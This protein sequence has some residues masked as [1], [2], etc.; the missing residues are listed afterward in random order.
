MQ[1]I[2][3][4]VQ[5]HRFR[6]F[7]DVDIAAEQ[8][9]VFSG[10]NNSG[11]SNILRALNL[12]FNSKTDYNVPF[13][14]DLDHN[15]AFRGAAGGKRSV[16]IVV[17][18][19]PVGNAALRF[20]FSIT[21]TFV[22]GKDSPDVE[23]HSKNIDIENQIRSGNGTITRQFT[24][25]LNKLR[26]IYVPAVRDKHFIRSLFLEF[27]QIVKNSARSAELD[28]AIEQVSTIFEAVSLNI[29][30]DFKKYIN[31]SADATLSSNVSELLNGL[32]INVHTGLQERTKQLMPD[33]SRL[34]D[35]P[36]DLF[37]SGDG[38][39]MTYMVYF[40][41]YL[42]QKSKERFIWGF[43]EPENSL[44]F[45]KIE[46]LAE[47]FYDDFLQHAQIFVTTHSPAF[48]NLRGRQ[49]VAAYRVYKRPLSM[50]EARSGAQNR[51]LTYVQD[52]D[53]IEEQLRNAAL[54]DEVY[55]ALDE[56]LHLAEQSLSIGEALAKLRNE[57]KQYE[58]KQQEF[59]QKMR[60]VFPEKFL[61]VR[62]QVLLLFGKA[63]WKEL[64]A[65][66]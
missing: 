15:K 14:Y 52:F 34:R 33:G 32:K 5:I 56:E 25:F 65:M 10:K 48:I 43:E 19:S 26:Y 55:S 42:T 64:D 2:I 58:R 20:P 31:L 27:E 49:N 66:G 59:D 45:S 23:Y 24:L 22:D 9:N 3:E 13:Y 60:E 54:S 50:E 16:R 57:K 11:K 47:R 28:N 6:S 61:S 4:S 51:Q 18:F 17:N 35:V 39:I 1:K 63:F 38:I 29:S 41:S 40:L 44:E 30:G 62:M 8:L 21:K 7:D 46:E 36:V 53:K 12:F 37:S